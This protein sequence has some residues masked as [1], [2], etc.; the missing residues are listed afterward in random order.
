[1]DHC[2]SLCVCCHD[3]YVYAMC[4]CSVYV[5][6]W[7]RVCHSVV[8]CWEGH[9]RACKH[10][11]YIYIPERRTHFRRWIG[12]TS[13]YSTPSFALAQLQALLGHSCSSTSTFTS[14][15][16]DPQHHHQLLECVACAATHAP[17][18]LQHISCDYV[19]T[20]YVTCVS[21]FFNL[22]HPLDFTSFAS[23]HPH[24]ARRGTLY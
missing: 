16:A 20:K 12:T 5:C 1:M 15:S 17:C 10:R 11:V 4:V 3:V 21:L 14:K 9:V 2:Y 13:F 7:V 24:P 23:Y 8:A 22:R 19:Y 18:F 6:A